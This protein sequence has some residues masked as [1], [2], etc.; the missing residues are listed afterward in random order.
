MPNVSEAE[1]TATSGTAPAA[2]EEAERNELKKEG[3]SEAAEEEGDAATAHVYE[4]LEITPTDETQSPPHSPAVVIEETTDLLKEIMMSGHQE[5]L[6]M[7]WDMV[8]DNRL[9]KQFSVQE[10]CVGAGGNDEDEEFSLVKSFFIFNFS[11]IYCVFIISR[12]SFLNLIYFRYF[13]S[14]IFLFTFLS[15]FSFF[16]FLT[17]YFCDWNQLLIRYFLPEYSNTF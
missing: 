7:P 4:T 5:N 2:K 14:R 6:D 8:A 13:L 9:S 1:E 10:I 12:H 3:K 15:F 17:G 11:L 16:L